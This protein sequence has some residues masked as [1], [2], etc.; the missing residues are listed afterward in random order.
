[1]GKTYIMNVSQTKN[2]SI[3]ILIYFTSLLLVSCITVTL[4]VN[5]K[6]EKKEKREKPKKFP[7][8][9]Q[10][11]T[12]GNCPCKEVQFYLMESKKPPSW[13]KLSG[14]NIINLSNE[15]TSMSQI[16]QTTI[17]QIKKRVTNANGFIVFLDLRDY[18]GSKIFPMRKNDQLYYYWGTCK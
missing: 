1:M 6:K 13:F 2:L 17:D 10:N 11:W 3:K 14:E 18:Y 12:K 16:P 9:T 7:K 15:I 8:P 5:E 4:P